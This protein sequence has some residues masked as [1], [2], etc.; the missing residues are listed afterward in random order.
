MTGQSAT[1]IERA[2]MSGAGGMCRTNEGARYGRRKKLLN[3]QQAR[4]AGRAGGARRAGPRSYLYS[5][6]EGRQAVGAVLP[7]RPRSSPNPEDAGG[8]EFELRSEEHTS[9]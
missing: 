7:A 8:H 5:V 4:L 3:T 9:E 6:H 2:D 1:S